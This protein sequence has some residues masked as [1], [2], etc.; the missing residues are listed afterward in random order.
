MNYQYEKYVDTIP[1]K[2][3][4]LRHIWSCLSLILFRPFGLIYFNYWRISLLKIFGAKIGKGSII[5]SSVYI[6][7]PW[8]LTVGSQTCLGPGVKLHFGETIIGSKVT[9]SQ[10]SYLC[11]ASHD[12]T[13][14]KM[15]F[16]SGRI[17][18][19]DYAWVAAEA[20]IMSG[21]TIGKGAIVGARAAV[22]KDVPEWSIVGGNPANFI[23]QRIIK[24]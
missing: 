3:K 22:F 6:P 2:D 7:A 24:C 14:V 1:K 5:H 9:I 11:S 10:R 19:N 21:V 8:K 20:F 4:I 16:I 18:I 17:V 13:N 15:S 12:V 23:K